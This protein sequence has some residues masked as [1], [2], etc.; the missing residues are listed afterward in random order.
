MHRQAYIGLIL[1]LAALS[2]CVLHRDP[3]LRQFKKDC[4]E[5]K[6]AGMITECP[7]YDPS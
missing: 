5:L 3:E 7:T 2:G 1:L 6:K 4:K